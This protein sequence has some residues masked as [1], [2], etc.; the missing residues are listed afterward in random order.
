MPIFTAAA[1]PCLF[2][3]LFWQ[4]RA[5]KIKKKKKNAQKRCL[6]RRGKKTKS[7]IRQ[8]FTTHQNSKF[9]HGQQ[10]KAEF[11]EGKGRGHE[12]DRK[13]NFGDLNL[14][15]RTPPWL[16]R[17]TRGPR[18]TAGFGSMRT[19]WFEGREGDLRPSCTCTARSEVKD[20][21]QHF[22][23]RKKQLGWDPLVTL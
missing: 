2:P 20:F 9:D 16:H 1:S 3:F 8:G 7:E 6:T 23:W 17:Y 14:T 21:V 4:Q 19:T 11:R 12:R 5:Q 10:K 22:L 15:L 13:S 18:I